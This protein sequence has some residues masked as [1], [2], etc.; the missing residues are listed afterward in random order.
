[1]LIIILDGAHCGKDGF[2]TFTHRRSSID[3]PGWVDWL[4]G[5][6]FPPY[7]VCYTLFSLATSSHIA[8]SKQAKKSAFQAKLLLHKIPYGRPG[9]HSSSSIGSWKKWIGLIA[10][11]VAI[12]AAA[13]GKN[14]SL[15]PMGDSGH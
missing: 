4:L 1:L 10:L 12:A 9:M 14:K 7:T 5:F 2:D 13:G 6:R 3:S 15:P 8:I 11:V